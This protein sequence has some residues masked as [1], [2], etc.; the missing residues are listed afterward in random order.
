MLS[1]C[2]WCNV[3]VH[4][5]DHMV[6]LKETVINAVEL[7]DAQEY[8]LKIPNK[9]GLTAFVKLFLRNNEF[10]FNG[11]LYKQVIRAPMGGI[12]SALCT[13]MHQINGNVLSQTTI[14]SKQTK[15]GSWFRTGIL[16]IHV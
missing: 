16:S 2:L 5:Y 1:Y 14:I 15:T 3:N 10:G 11:Q 9:K 6:N 4:K 12:F 8:P 7:F 13:Y